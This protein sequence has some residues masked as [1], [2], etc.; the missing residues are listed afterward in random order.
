MVRHILVTSS[1]GGNVPFRLSSV[2]RDLPAVRRH[3]FGVSEQSMALFQPLSVT[4]GFAML[5]V[6]RLNFF[7]FNF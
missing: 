6:R 3:S 4:G 5:V 1:A 2:S 7:H